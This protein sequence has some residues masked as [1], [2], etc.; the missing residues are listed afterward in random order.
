MNLLPG[1]TNKKSIGSKSQSGS[2]KLRL[3]KLPKNS[4]YYYQIRPLYQSI[5]DVP[6]EGCTFGEQ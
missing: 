4:N 3:N 5:L 6:N 2:K 1:I